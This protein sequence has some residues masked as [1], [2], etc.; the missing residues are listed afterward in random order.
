MVVQASFHVNGLVSWVDTQRHA[1]P[2]LLDKSNFMKPGAH[3][4]CAW[5]KNWIHTSRVHNTYIYR[6]ECQT[7]A[8]VLRNTLH[9]VILQY[10]FTLHMY[11]KEVLI[12]V[13]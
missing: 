11:C 3:R 9:K 2:D 10:F 4:P 12:G 1:Q 7:H 13:D 5:F 8:I 6:G